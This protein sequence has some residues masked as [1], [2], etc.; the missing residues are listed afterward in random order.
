MS[1]A[2]DTVLAY[3]QRTKHQ[4]QRYAAGPETLDW[5]AQPSPFR[6]WAGSPLTMLPLVADELRT[7]WSQM[8]DP[9]GLPPHAMGLASVACLLELSFALT[10]WKQYGPDRW[11]L[12]ANPSS[13]NLH[14]T[15]VYVIAVGVSG[16]ADGLYH[17]APREHALALRAGFATAQG[18]SIKGPALWIGLSSI[19]WREAWKYGERAFR[20]CQLDTGHAVGALAYAAA[21][22]GWHTRALAE[23]GFAE[24]AAIM[25]LDRD[26]DFGLAEREEPEMLIRVALASELDSDLEQGELPPPPAG[27]WHGQASR[28]DRHPMYRWPVID[29]VSRATRAMA[30]DRAQLAHAASNMK[31]A[32]PPATCEASTGTTAPTN[33]DALA[34]SVIRGRRSAQHFDKRA[35][36]PLAVFLRMMAALMP[37]RSLPFDAWPQTAS[38]HAVVYAH[39][40]DGLAPGAY[41]L[42]RTAQGE[43]ALRAAIHTAPDW[44]RVLAGG[45]A[46]PLWCIAAHPAL[47]GTLRTLSCHQAIGSDA[48]FAV[49][50]IADFAEPVARQ[51]SAY[52]TLYQEAGLMGQVLYL[53]AEAEGFRGTG[54]GCYF[55]DAVHELLGMKD[56]AMQVLYHFTVGV[57]MVDA[58]IVTEAPY[59]HRAPVAIPSPGQE[60][61]TT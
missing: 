57:P 15:E 44:A 32:N 26:S 4:P 17:Y 40:V 27:E 48:C 55:D 10:A 43:A 59:A 51:A 35:T 37:Q 21:A 46:L 31:S 53:Q 42:A 39:R 25:G 20:Y 47:A 13:G 8:D 30:A 1:T 29:E 19:Q 9:V 45:G 22:L 2:Q 41:V 28:L 6:E 33:H 18:A 56:Q 12:R 5:D 16:L 61:A 52:R 11:A 60:V 34:S 24:L 54:I 36:M 49:S 7:T 14:P 58:R 38:V 23:P 3:H 50:L